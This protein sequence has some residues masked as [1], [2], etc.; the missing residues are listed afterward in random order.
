MWLPTRQ[1]WR[2][3]R[4]PASPLH[5]DAAMA[6]VITREGELNPR[7]TQISQEQRDALWAAFVTS[8]LDKHP[9]EFREMVAKPERVSA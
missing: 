8:W 7:T 1:A 3:A 5:K 4:L 2:S 6:I 9:E